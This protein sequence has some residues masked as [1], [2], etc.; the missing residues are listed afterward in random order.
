M[1]EEMRA[2]GAPEHSHNEP[3]VSGIHLLNWPLA[4]SETPASNFHAGDKSMADRFRYVSEDFL[5]SLI[6][7]LVLEILKRFVKH[8]FRA[9]N[10]IL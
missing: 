9:E 4:E 1:R 10:S 2:R 3:A 7:P 5:P 8:D 6:S